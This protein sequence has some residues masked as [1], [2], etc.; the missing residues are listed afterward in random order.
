MQSI[1][2]AQFLIITVLFLSSGCFAASSAPAPVSVVA[3]LTC[4]YA[5][6]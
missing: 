1:N 3:P 5:S 2:G 6:L 4:M